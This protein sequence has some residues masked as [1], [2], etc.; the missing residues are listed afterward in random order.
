MAYKV[1]RWGNSS[2]T[3]KTIPNSFKAPELHRKVLLFLAHFCGLTALHM[4]HGLNSLKG[5]I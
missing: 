2:Y 3:E 1:S 4:D 5:V